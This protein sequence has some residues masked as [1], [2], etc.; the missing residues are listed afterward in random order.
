MSSISA[1]LTETL[2]E[3]VGYNVLLD[4]N[5]PRLLKTVKAGLAYEATMD[6]QVEV[7]KKPEPHDALVVNGGMLVWDHDHHHLTLAMPGDEWRHITVDNKVRA[8]IRAHLD[9][10]E[11]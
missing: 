8:W 5:Y 3:L 9:K 4:D 10:G 1:A 2:S 7:E 11:R 6:P